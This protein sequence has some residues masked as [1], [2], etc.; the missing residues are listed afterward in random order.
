MILEI[1]GYTFENR[2]GNKENGSL[3][4]TCPYVCLLVL[5]LSFFSQAI[6]ANTIS[7][8]K[9]LNNFGCT[10]I[11]ANVRLV[12][13]SA[14]VLY[15]SVILET[16]SSESLISQNHLGKTITCSRRFKTNK[17]TINFSNQIVITEGQQVFLR[18]Y[19]YKNTFLISVF[20]LN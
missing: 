1:E 9:M 8:P 20:I 16:F 3:V 14:W 7:T 2:P 18:F 6:I 4:R 19:W 15:V 12:R 11:L 10:D 13:R 17:V 5:D